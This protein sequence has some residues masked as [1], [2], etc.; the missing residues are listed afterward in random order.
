MT[1]VIILGNCLVPDMNHSFPETSPEL[2]LLRC[3]VD[4]LQAI[5]DITEVICGRLK[6][7]KAKPPEMINPYLN[8]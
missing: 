1:P 7:V 6:T 3:M 4:V 2:D 5:F 8:G